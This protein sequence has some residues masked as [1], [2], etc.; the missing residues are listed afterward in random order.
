LVVPL[1]RLST[2]SGYVPDFS[3][4]ESPS[5]PV[6]A[7]MTMVELYS[8]ERPAPVTSIGVDGR[9]KRGNGKGQFFDWP[10]AV[11][12]KYVSSYIV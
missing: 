6:E 7:E 3:T 11:L 5:P 1:G 10:H 12:V 4:K 9:Q 8:F 2:F